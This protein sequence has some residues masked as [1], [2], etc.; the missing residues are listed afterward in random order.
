MK[1]RVI[2]SKHF[3]LSGNTYIGYTSV[4][5]PSL[6]YGIPKRENIIW[7]QLQ[8]TNKMSKWILTDQND[9]CGLVRWKYTIDPKFG[10][11]F[12]E[13]KDYEIHIIFDRVPENTKFRRRLI[14]D[15]SED[16]SK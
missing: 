5:K 9:A 10:T 2:N 4:L 14:H 13:L 1:S 6:F 12:P 11:K 7:F 15:Y 16:N 3:E 8:E